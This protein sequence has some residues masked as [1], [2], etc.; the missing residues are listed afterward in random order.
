MFY[1]LDK[2]LIVNTLQKLVNKGNSS[3]VAVAKAKAGVG[4]SPASGKVVDAAKLSLKAADDFISSWL[5]AQTHKSA[6][7]TA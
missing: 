4:R 2:K 3:N 7:C 6:D 1:N 5:S